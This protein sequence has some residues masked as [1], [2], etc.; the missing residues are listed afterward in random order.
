MG[1]CQRST[2]HV[3]VPPWWRTPTTNH[4]KTRHNITPHPRKPQETGTSATHPP[5][6]SPPPEPLRAASHTPSRKWLPV[7]AK[8]LPRRHLVSYD[9]SRLGVR[10]R[11]C[12]PIS[13]PWSLS[14]FTVPAPAGSS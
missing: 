3:D 1:W 14:C 13:V 11:P 8:S 12:Q 4:K 6:P 7:Q 2:K 9:R 10:Q 5:P